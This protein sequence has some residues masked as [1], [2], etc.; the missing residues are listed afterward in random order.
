MQFMQK[1][2]VFCAHSALK[3]FSRTNWIS[4]MRITAFIIMN[5]CLTAEL[6]IATPTNGQNAEDKV[7]SITATD[8]TFPKLAEIIE[9]RTGVTIMFE[10]KKEVFQ[11]KMTVDETNIRLG[12]LLD[13]V[14]LG[15]SLK[16][17]ARENIIR[18][19]ET[20]ENTA[21]PGV[22]FKSTPISP[23]LTV[24]PITGIIRSLDGQPIAGANIAVKGTKRGTITNSNG[25]F[26]I[27]VNQSDILVI[28]S[29]GYEQKEIP[30]SSG[31]NS[32][33]I[34]LN[35]SNSKLDE[36]R[37]IAY[38]TTSKRLSTSVTTGI[39]ADDIK[40][41][42]VNNPLLALAGRTTG[43]VIEQA[44]G[45]PG[46][47][48]KIKIQGQNSIAKGVD[49]FYVVDGVPYPANLL[50]TGSIILGAV[51]NNGSDV[52][53][54]TGNPFSFINPSD[55][56]SIEVLK[57]ADAT[58]IY[59]SRAANGAILITTKRGKA[60][61]TTLDV[62]YQ[63]GFGK[64]AKRM[65]LLN[66]QQYLEMRHEAYINDGFA[67]P[68]HS[69][70]VFEKNFS[71]YDL[72]VY[73]QN[74]Y[75]DWQKLLTGGTSQYSNLQTSVS[76]GT[77]QT[78]FR[79]N[80]GYHK[81]TTVFPGDFSDVK[82]SIG[83]NVNHATENQKFK[84]QFSA[85]YLNDNNRLPGDDLTGSAL[86]LAPNSPALFHP[87]GSLNW[88]R[89]EIDPNTHDS[90]STFSNPLRS[91]LN[92]T[93]F[94]TDN[95]LGSA[96]VSYNIIKGLF[97]RAS[98]G[99]S[100][101]KSTELNT[102]PL[103]QYAPEERKFS[104]RSARYGNSEIKNWIIEPQLEYNTILGSSKLQALVGS[105]FQE[106]NNDNI[107]YM[108]TGYPNDEV[109]A[110]ARSASSII[111]LGDHTLSQYK[112]AALFGKLNYNIRDKYIIN[113]TARRDGSSRFG[114]ANKF[115][116]FGAIGGAWIFSAEDFVQNK[117]KAL[118]FGKLRGSY[119]TT[120]NDQ[121]GNYTFLNIYNVIAGGVSYNGYNGI[122]PSTH[123]NPYI[124]WELTRK[125]QLGVDL[126][127]IHDRILVSINYYRNQSSNQLVNYIL[128]FITGFGDIMRNFPA[129]VRNTGLEMSIN[130]TN[131]QTKSFTWSSSFNLTIA[132]NKLVQF[133][134]LETSTYK[135]QLIIGEPVN[136]LKLF[137]F[138]GVDPQTGNMQ[139]L[140]AEGKPTTDV[141]YEKDRIF[142]TD[143]NPKYYGGLQNSFSY[144]GFDLTFL[145]QFTKQM[146]SNNRLSFLLGDNANQSTDV[147]RRWQKPGDVTDVPRFSTS[148]F[149]F[150]ATSSNYA[151]TDASYI[152]LKNASIGWNVP[153]EWLSRI[154]V[155][156]LKFY[157][158]GQNLLTITHYLGLD[159]ESRS[160]INIPPLRMITFGAQITL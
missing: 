1:V 56:Q 9:K 88:E 33:S 98:F 112:Y 46:S 11:T 137:Q 134:N 146:G 147:L 81:E 17:T 72:T 136:V 120:G 111:V 8:I 71:N 140:N 59:G 15:K 148:T 55:I 114:T 75:T 85:N 131:I 74:R 90:V 122:G 79:L 130:S 13:K 38:G 132:R 123:Y 31:M 150:T 102:T 109:L 118:S 6:L 159:P 24:P 96:N 153:R 52:G 106:T 10:N 129:T 160:S 62:N 143:I 117:I 36:I 65:N 27:Q 158:Q 133:Q 40:S 67:I 93:N 107:R 45:V 86:F 23:S 149:L 54:G 110:D 22:D 124:Q 26:S 49:P 25:S 157:A 141:N 116:T 68:T 41:Q 69:S 156:H 144:K 82:A 127:F 20:S 76:G 35:I 64:V 12:N 44:T 152:R 105:T 128:P 14:L 115:H 138:A 3:T 91:I 60:G 7:V 63:Q 66:T 58:A 73:D 101:L 121:I 43:I 78:A 51:S 142:L 83:I 100:L 28:S 80:G 32:V 16:W 119:G 154:K 2:R 135:D 94:K 113:I 104:D 70:P 108:G 47:T 145:F 155:Q 99:Y 34:T 89:I 5:I 48:L 77:N 103:T 19:D 61:K 30:V 126:G 87:D 151:N 4:I 84:F 95:L 57:D 42:P 39:N 37:V 92:K 125:L 50:P 18:I 21:N 29:I 139:Y 97:A 53:S